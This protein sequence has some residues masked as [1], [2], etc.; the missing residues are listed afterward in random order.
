MPKIF[1]GMYPLNLFMDKN[2]TEMMPVLFIS[3]TTNMN[4]F[5]GTFSGI[6]PK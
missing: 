1:I 4:I 5:I 2:R 6:F 3:K